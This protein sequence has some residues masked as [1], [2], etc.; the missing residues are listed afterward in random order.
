MWF[1]GK[2][3]VVLAQGGVT[4]SCAQNKDWFPEWELTGGG[5]AIPALLLL[6]LEGLEVLVEREMEQTFRPPRVSA[7]IGG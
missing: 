1:L 2:G 5:K 7:R 3:G 4:G 6:A